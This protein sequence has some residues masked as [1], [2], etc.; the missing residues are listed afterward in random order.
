MGTRTS[1]AFITSEKGSVR[2]ERKKA[3]VSIKEDLSLELY[4]GWSE[5]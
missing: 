1:L 3:D 4:G 5:F 2:R